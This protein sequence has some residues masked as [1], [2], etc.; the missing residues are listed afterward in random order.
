MIVDAETLICDFC[1]RMALA[2]EEEGG[3]FES[4]HSRF[5]RAIR[6]AYAEELLAIQRRNRER[7]FIDSGESAVENAAEVNRNWYLDIMRNSE[8][9]DV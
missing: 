9:K 7:D 3:C 2:V 4:A 5:H 8:F 1:D 6:F